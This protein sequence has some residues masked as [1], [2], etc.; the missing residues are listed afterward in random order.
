MFFSREEYTNLLPGAKLRALRDNAI[1]HRLRKL[2]LGMYYTY[3][4]VVMTNGKEAMRVGKNMQKDL[5]RRKERESVAIIFFY[6]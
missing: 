5:E 6:F 4:H 1:L 2:Y 3:M